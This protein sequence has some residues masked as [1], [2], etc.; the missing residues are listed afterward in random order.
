VASTRA[1]APSAV[2]DSRPAAEQ[3][4]DAHVILSFD[5][6]EHHRIEAAAGRALDPGL[7]ERSAE[8]LEPATR[9]LLDA[10][11]E[12]GIKA[13]FFVVAEIACSNPDLVRAIHRAGHEVASHSWSH[14]RIHN[15]SPAAFREDVRTS[16]D[17]LEQ[18]TGQIVLGYRAPTFSIVRQTAWALDILA[19]TGLAYD[20]SVYPVRHDRYGVPAAPRVPYLARGLE[21]SLLEIPPATLRLLGVNIPTGGGG[22]FRLLPLA[23]MEWTIRQALGLSR[24]SVVMLYFHPWEFD[25]D[26]PR[27]PLGRLNRF[28]T[29]VG[30]RHSRARLQTLLAGHRFSRAAEVAKQLDQLRDLLPR[31]TLAPAEP[32]L[33][34]V[35]EPA[36]LK[37]SQDT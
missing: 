11:A 7:Q 26:Q 1:V 18:V 15:L 14:R 20:S 35:L 32:P 23:L 37:L 36:R 10:L 28:R 27:L 6:E 34:P 25:P 4:A 31:F 17:A 16:K 8:R 2:V 30:I 29:Y 33:A 12:H 21:H 22:Y 5:V 24:P 9:W 3:A 13:T 19:E